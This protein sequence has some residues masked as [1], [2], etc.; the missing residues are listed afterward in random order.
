MKKLIKSN[1]GKTIYFAIGIIAIVI[2]MIALIT[3]TNSKL[4][5]STENAKILFTEETHDFGKVEQGVTLEYSY[6]FTNEGDEALKIEKVQP[7]CGC[8]GATTDGKI[9][10][11]EGESG[12]IKITFN[13]Q[14]REGHQEKHIKVFTNDKENPQKDLKFVCDIVS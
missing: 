11:T 2:L 6:K 5:A 8:T 7:S 14:G 3:F 9:E 12:E 10:Y 1:T 13:T 4:T